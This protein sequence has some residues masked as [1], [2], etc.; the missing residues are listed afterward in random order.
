[1]ESF[2]LGFKYK[3]VPTDTQSER[4]ASWAG[5]CRFLYNLCLEQR[6][7][8]WKQHKRSLNYNNQANELKDIKKVESYHWIKDVPAQCLQQSM[9][10]LDKAYQK[11]FKK[12][13]GFPKFKR[14]NSGDSIR[15]PQPKQFKL[16]RVNGNKGFLTLPKIGTIALNLSRDIVGTI[17]SCTI[18]RESDG[19]YVSFC[20]ERMIEIP[21]NHKPGIGID[22]GISQSFALSNETNYT[23]EELMLPPAAKEIFERIKVLQKRLSRKEKKS[24]S[25][26][27]LVKKI[28]RLHCKIARIR[29]DFLHK[30]SNR[31]TKN[32]SQIVL[33][34]LK[35]KNMSKSAK[36][37]ILEPGKN[38]AAKRGL[39]R[40]I[41]FQGW[42]LFA[43][44]LSYKSKL[45]GGYLTLVPPQFTS[46]RCSQPNC[47]YQSRENRKG[48]VFK[49][50]NCGYTDDA[51]ENAAKNIFTAG[52]AGSACGD[53]G[54]IP[55]CEA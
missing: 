26:E 46:Q 34:D 52:R 32:H 28:S 29:H 5:T 19:W 9:M 36:G 23:K 20:A 50:I 53:V 6:I 49:C 37:T 45:R 48:K 17:R 44:M 51:D 33:E 22:R 21:E 18:K 25:W 11:F 38:V 13:L 42:G 24:N 55:I 7:L 3:L 35:I 12:G 4:L 1:V 43:T 2:F 27:K 47:L 40:E 31:L 39:N 14:K 10:D 16:V 41:L 54:S 30:L 15:F 8:E